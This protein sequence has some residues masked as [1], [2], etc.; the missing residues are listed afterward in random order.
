MAVA[1]AMWGSTVV[2]YAPSERMKHV[3]EKVKAVFTQQY[4]GKYV[5]WFVVADPRTDAPVCTFGYDHYKQNAQL[6]MN[7]VRKKMAAAPVGS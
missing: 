5:P 3:P 6:I 1:R 2:V 4:C 7:Q